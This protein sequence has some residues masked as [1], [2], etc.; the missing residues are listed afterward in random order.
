MN[1][2]KRQTISDPN[3]STSLESELAKDEGTIVECIFNFTPRDP[4]NT[5]EMAIT[6]GERLKIYEKGTDGWWGGSRVSNP[7]HRGLF[8]EAY[9]KV[10]QT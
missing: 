9:V 6:K 5:F 7:A 4:T 8:P 3:F 1:P 10:I 2:V